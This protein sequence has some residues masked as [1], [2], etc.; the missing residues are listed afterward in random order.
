MI[1]PALVRKQRMI[2]W[3]LFAFIM[4]TVIIGIRMGYASLSYDRIIPTLLGQ[5]TFKEEF[6]LFSIRL[7]RIVITL[8]AGMAL[9]LS[10]AILQGITRNDLADPGIISINSGA[11]VA[12]AVF[13][14]SFQS[15]PGRSFTPCLS[16]LLPELY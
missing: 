15:K 2:L 5:G 9:A 16:S 10:G 3:I 1:E 13:F 14:Y 12:I 6:I 8:L 11:G 4:I 7:P